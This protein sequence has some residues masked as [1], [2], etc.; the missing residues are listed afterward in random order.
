MKPKQLKTR[1]RAEFLYDLGRLRQVLADK[2]VLHVVRKAT[3][4]LLDPL[5]CQYKKRFTP[6]GQFSLDDNSYQYFFHRYNRTWAN[7]RS[8]EV[9][10]ALKFIQ[11]NSHK[12]I[13]EVGNVLSHYFPICYDVLDKYESV[14]G[15]INQDILEYEPSKGF[16]LIVSISTLE[17][18][19]WDEKDRDPNKIIQAVEKMTGWLNPG[20]KLV[21]TL[22]IGY[23]S[24]MD[25]NLDSEKLSFQKQFYL[26]RINSE[27]RWEETTWNEIRNVRYADPFPGANALVIGINE[28]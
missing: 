5:I 12:R 20:G 15:V 6:P 21:V 16:D 22:P 9:P 11:E 24:D 25:Q 2:G 17:H 26:K 1:M 8:V 18:V 13:L 7:E 23:N 28:N 3:A 14:S 4:L 10:I 27:N 19:G